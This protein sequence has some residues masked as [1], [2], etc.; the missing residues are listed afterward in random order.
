MKIFERLTNALHRLPGIGPKAA[1]RLAYHILQTPVPEIEE[2]CNALLSAKKEMKLCSSCYNFT[3]TDPCP[4]CRDET[5]NKSLLCVV[6]EPQ[7]VYTLE[8]TKSFNGYYHVIGGAFSPL[9]GITAEDLRI[10]EL[11]DRVQKNGYQ[12][13]ILALDPDAEGEMTI[14]YLTRVLKP[15]KIKVSRIAYGIPVGGDLEYADKLTLLRAIE[16][17]QVL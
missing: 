11:V 15:Y 9:D 3:E 14:N 4:I 10:K 8:R 2:L 13:I 7:D 1:E 6:E 12:E 16:G 5:R 17:R